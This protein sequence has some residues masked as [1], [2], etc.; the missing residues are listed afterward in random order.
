M[1]RKSTAAKIFIFIGLL[2]IMI[3]T[4]LIS[5]VISSLSVRFPYLNIYF[6]I[7]SFV[8]PLIILGTVFILL[9]SNL[10]KKV[11]LTLSLGALIITTLSGIGTYAYEHYLNS[12]SIEERGI[13]LYDYEPFTNSTALARLEN[14]ASLKLDDNLISLDGATALYPVYASFVEAVYKEGDYHPYGARDSIVSST[15]TG[16]AYR[17][18][19][20]GEVD[21]IF[22]AGPSDEQLDYAERNGVELTLTPIGKEAFVFFVNKE[23]PVDDLSLDEVIKIYSGE[24]TNWKDVGGD[25]QAIEAFQRPQGSGSQ[26]ALLS[27]MGDKEVMTPPNELVVSGMGGIIST[28][29]NYKNHRY[30]IGYSFRYYSMELV[31]DNRIKHL[32]LNGV[33]PSKESI[34]DETYPISAPF[35]I[36]TAGSTNPNIEAFIEWVL[37]SEGQELIEK[38]GYVPIN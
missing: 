16:S 26:T 30:A 36:V 11:I 18:L 21:M 4:S 5:F 19:I 3:P 24:I 37:S 29:A 32:S 15:Q 23:N 20:D 17:R 8:V 14:E 10:K 35:Y 12:I 34:V 33:M 22:A 13:N 6:Q 25:D 1:K 9:F 27:I 28:T 7:I 2:I 38:S 31:N